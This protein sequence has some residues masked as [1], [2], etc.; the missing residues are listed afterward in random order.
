MSW[1]APGALAFVCPRYG[2]EVLGG[3]ET[4]VRQM[5]ER[6]TSAG[7][8]VEVLTTCALDHYT[9]ANH[10][11]PGEA[12][13]NGVTVRRFPVQHGKG[14]HR[15]AIGDRITAGLPTSFSDQE[16][17]LNDGFR[18]AQLFHFLM[19][20]HDRYHTIV[21]TPYMFWTTYAAANAAPQKTVLRPCLHDESFARLDIYRAMFRSVRGVVFNSQPEA[22]LAHR[23]YELPQ[24]SEV[25]GEGMEIPSRY[26]PGR[27]RRSYG[28]DGPF[29]IYA[30]RR[31]WGKNVDVLV[32]YFGR[33]AAGGGTNLRLVLTG[34]GQ[35]HIPPAYQRRVIDLGYVSEEDKNDALAAAVATCQPSMWE[36]FS[37][38]LMD[39]WLASTPVLGFGG[40]AVTAYHIDQSGG[41]LAYFD[42][43]EFEVGLEILADSPALAARMGRS[44]REYVLAH[45]TWDQ[46]I[47]RF[48]KCIEVW[49]VEA[50]E[51]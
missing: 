40:C 8:P 43:A 22:D 48:V 20:H 34:R 45:H 49:A 9:W 16:L 26:D 46:V 3:A 2:V 32:E 31:E 24:R 29:V 25:V 15:K 4:V 37:R 11:P 42:D 33:F 12:E 30:G 17:W 28:I 5:A 23:L 44:G 35:V 41:G 1:S 13:V 47:E 39:S 50:V 27:F 6:L 10:F 7:Y 38:L 19:D 36:S 18:S 14:H 51:G 21:P